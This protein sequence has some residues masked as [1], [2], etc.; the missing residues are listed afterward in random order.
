MTGEMSLVFV[1]GTLKTNQ[2]NHYWLTN[3]ANG[4]SN[5]V[6]KGKTSELYPMVIGT[7]YNIPYLVKLAGT[8]NEIC[9]EI[10]EIDEQMLA[11]L[12]KVEDHPNHYVREQIEVNGDN[13]YG[14]IYFVL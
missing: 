6:S 8:G 9:G 14:C 12:D 3:N 10:Y 2:P 1:Y 4:Q 11:T 13:E 5:L 7:R